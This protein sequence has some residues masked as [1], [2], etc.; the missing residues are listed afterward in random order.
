M[1]NAY[2]VEEEKFIPFKTY[3]LEKEKLAESTAADYVK[4]IITICREEGIDH[5]YLQEHIEEICFEYTDGDKKALGQ[6]SHNSYRGALLQ[7]KKFV[8]DH[9]GTLKTNSN[10]KP[11][12]HFEVNRVPN[13]HFGVIKLYDENNNVIDT[14]TTLSVEHHP[15]KEASRDLYFKC[16]NMLFR[17]V[18]NKDNT[19][20][21]DLLRLLNV[22]LT[23][24]GNVI[25]H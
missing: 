4:R 15:A 24:D 6:R 8:I 25:I 18:Y 23:I 13:E 21:L 19:K 14:D 20:L 10:V 11:K 16:I 9:H 3:L 12:Y 7:F 5:Q 2:K 22:P 1:K 17:S